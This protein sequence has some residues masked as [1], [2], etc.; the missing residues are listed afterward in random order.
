MVTMRESEHGGAA[1]KLSICR[2]RQLA[3]PMHSSGQI[4]GKTEQKET[5]VNIELLF[6]Y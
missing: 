3:Y 1:I 6:L 2:L 5:G 4:F